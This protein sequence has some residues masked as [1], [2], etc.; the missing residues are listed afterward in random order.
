M[1]NFKLDKDADGILLVTFDMPGRSMNV[2]NEGSMGEIAEFT[3]MIKSDESIKGAVIAS[4]NLWQRRTSG[5][6]SPREVR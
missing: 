4:A 1:K 6:A 3:Q 5:P 2:L